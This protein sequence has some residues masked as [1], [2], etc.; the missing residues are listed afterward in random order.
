VEQQDGS[1]LLEERAHP[2]RCS[3]MQRWL[4]GTV[5]VAWWR[6]RGAGAAAGGGH[7]AEAR[8]A[9]QPAKARWPVEVPRLQSRDGCGRRDGDAAEA[10]CAGEEDG[11]GSE[12]RAQG[13]G[14]RRRTA[15][16]W[17]PGGGLQGQE[18]LGGGRSAWPRACDSDP[19]WRSVDRRLRAPGK[20]RSGRRCSICAWRHQIEARRRSIC[21]QR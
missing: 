16:T 17:F 12:S 13:S 18:Q 7:D 10:L 6:G 14:S 4:G 20:C 1:I 9:R 21:A 3:P 15:A 11:R 8:T 2:S 5:R 19:R